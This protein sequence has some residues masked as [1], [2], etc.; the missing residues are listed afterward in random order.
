MAR[1]PAA[2]RIEIRFSEAIEALRRQLEM[3]SEEWLS[4]VEEEN[5]AATK[6]A[7]EVLG[8]VTA[9][10]LAAVL[11]AMETGGTIADFRRDYDRIVEEHG[12]SYKGDAGWHSQLIYRMHTSR[13]YSAGRWEQAQ[14]LEAAR[15]GTY[16][17]RLLSVGDHRVRHTHALMHG[18]IRPISDPYWLTHWPPNGFNCRCYVQVV[19][20]TMLKRFG[21]VV[22]PDSAPAM[23]VPPD[24]GYWRGPDVARLAH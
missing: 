18:I 9:D 2:R 20:A 10:L 13:A 7:G 3:G 19:T 15:P 21:W 24:E 1:R 16:F 23:G 6:T 4:I 8:A 12:W 11:E 5:A 17:G 22:T 14:R